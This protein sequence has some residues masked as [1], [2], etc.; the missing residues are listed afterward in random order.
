MIR[1]V[2]AIKITR[3]YNIAHFSILICWGNILMRKKTEFPAYVC[4][5]FK[6]NIWVYRLCGREKK[7]TEKNGGIHKALQ[8]R[9]RKFDL[10]D[11]GTLR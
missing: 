1:V 4:D 11:R 10:D 2:I 6:N 8:Y 7:E 9:S 5:K 3:I